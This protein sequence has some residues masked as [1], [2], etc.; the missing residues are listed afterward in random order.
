M[1][2]CRPHDTIKREAGS[3]PAQGAILLKALLT[4]FRR[5]NNSKHEATISPATIEY[6]GKPGIGGTFDGIPPVTVF[7]TVTVT[8]LLSASAR[9]K[10]I[11][12]IPITILRRMRKG[13]LRY[14][15]KFAS[16]NFISFLT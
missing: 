4:Y 9:Q 10:E 16:K 2:G 7:V 3:N 13:C 11:N 1:R 8:T 6:H 5:F 14:C 15:L 12:T